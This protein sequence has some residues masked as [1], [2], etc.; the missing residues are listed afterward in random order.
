MA[1]FIRRGVTK[2]RFA[3]ALA[4]PNTAVIRSEITGST[5]LTPSV[6]EINGWMLEAAQ[7]A[8]PDMGSDFDSNVPGTTSAAD[9]N[10]V[11]YEDSATNAVE[12]LLPIGASGFILLLRKG[13]VVASPSLDI[14]PVRVASRSAQFAAGNDPAR[15]QV[16]FSIT[17]KPKLDSVIPA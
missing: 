10:L 17:S 15:F 9:S 13:D 11:F 3:T 5:D 12:T 2:I 14:F 4:T 16:N 1:R 8:T 7:V 6:A